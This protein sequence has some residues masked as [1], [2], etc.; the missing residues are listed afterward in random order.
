MYTFR[1]KS[2]VLRRTPIGEWNIR[3]FWRS[4]FCNF[5][6]SQKTILRCKVTFE[7]NTAVLAGPV[8]YFFESKINHL[9]YLFRIRVVLANIFP[10][11]LFPFGI[12]IIRSR[13]VLWILVARAKV[14]LDNMEHQVSKYCPW[15]PPPPSPYLSVSGH[16]TSQLRDNY[17]QV[18]NDK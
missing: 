13:Y 4:P 18:P 12:I 1:F 6:T 5:S 17:T 2:T 10:P 9:F 11:P 16:F 15:C 7:L 3:T 8:S 14:D